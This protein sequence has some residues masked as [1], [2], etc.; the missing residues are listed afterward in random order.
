MWPNCTYEF[1]LRDGPMRRPAKFF[2]VGLLLTLGWPAPGLGQ[3]IPVYVVVERS[4]GGGSGNA[5]QVFHDRYDPTTAAQSSPIG[6]ISFPTSVSGNQRRLTESNDATNPAGLFTRFT[7]GTGFAVTGY[8]A[9]VGTGSVAGSNPA[10]IN[11]IIGTVSST[12]QIDTSTGFNNGGTNPFRSVA[13][14]DGTAF[15]GG[16]G[17]NSDGVVYVSAAGNIVNFTRI[18]GAINRQVRIFNNS[19]FYS[20]SSSTA[21]LNGVFL[22]GTAGTLPTTT[23]TATQ[24][25]GLGTSG[26]G[27]PAPT[28]FYLF[29]NPLN[30]NNWNGTGLD[31]L[32]V[33]DERAGASGG[34]IQ[35]WV[36][37]GSTWVLSGTF[38]SSGGFRGLTA[39]IDTGG[40]SPIVSLWGTTAALSSN[41][42]VF[43]QDTLSATSGSYGAATVLATAPSGNVFRGVEIA[44]VAVPEPTAALCLI[45]AGAVGVQVYLRRRR[46]GGTVDSGP[47]ASLGE[48]EH[49][50][51]SKSTQCSR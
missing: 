11:R 30:S 7:D 37:N 48:V 43:L 36:F 4:G 28:G 10:T 23:A 49:E 18:I 13:S 50:P 12:F 6:S 1:A 34:G 16:I 19:L 21:S 31:T 51:D 47:S 25:P 17:S 41:S 40:A 15:W 5:S 26:T 39:T 29:D 27:T 33:A 22:L 9:A 46:V 32:Y 14:V 8:D 38:T 42:L 24:L 35:R 44:A 2:I 3:L 45:L 20:N